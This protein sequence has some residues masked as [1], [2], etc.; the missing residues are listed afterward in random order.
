MKKLLSLL[1]AMSMV[2]SLAACGGNEENTPVNGS[3]GSSQEQTEEGNTG[4]ETRQNRLIYGTNTQMTGDMAVSAWWSNNATDALI[5]DLMNDYTTV[6][7]SKEG[8]IYVINESVCEGIEIVTNE[9]GTKTYTETIKQGLT[10]NNGEPI[11]AADYCAYFLVYDSPLLYELESYAYPSDIVGGLDYQWGETNYIAGVRM[12]DEY[13]FSLTVT[14]EYATYYH[15]LLYGQCGPLYLPSYITGELTVKDDGEGIY[16]DGD[17]AIDADMVNAVRW[18]NYDHPVSAGPYTLTSL[19]IGSYTATLEINPYYVGNYEGQKPSIESLVVTYAP[20]ETQF[21]SLKT[22]GVDML[23]KIGDGTY[24]DQGLNMVEQG[25]FDYIN[26]PRSG[27]GY[28]RFFGDGGPTQFIEVRHA[29]AYLLDRNE[30]ASTFTGGYGSVVDGPYGDAQWMYQESEELFSEVLNHYDYNPSKAIEE[31]EAGGWTLN[32]DGTP[33]SGTG[34]RYKEVTE[35]EAGNYDLNVTLEDG[36]ILMPLYIR[37][38]SSTDNSVSDLLVTMLAE[39]TQVADAG[40]V[41]QQD[42]VTFNEMM[43]W[44][45]R[46]GDDPKYSSYYY[47]MTNM[48]DTIYPYYDYAHYYATPDTEDGQYYVDSGWNVNHIYDHELDETSVALSYRV[49]PGDTEDYLQKFQDFIIR[50]NEVLPDL[51]LYSNEYHTFFCDWLKGYEADD[52]WTFQYAILYAYIENA[53]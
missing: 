9:D 14:E 17:G 38:I 3:Q 35:E 2:L 36:R 47:G 37:W 46:Y 16:L 44:V 28:L 29:I 31:L 13:T 5:R 50:W 12:L 8:G 23:D 21:D 40:M 49:T 6:S 15:E 53:E 42:V 45:Y 25:G 22:G 34:L 24:I 4:A 51:P 20:A 41:I 33:Y 52:F 48:G 18:Q 39:G 27:Y 1:L 30:F 7:L 19:D 43:N 10:W 11:T 26:F 32:A